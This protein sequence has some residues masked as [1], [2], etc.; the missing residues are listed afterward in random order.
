MAYTALVL[1][2]FFIKSPARH[3]CGVMVTGLRAKGWGSTMLRAKVRNMA[4][5]G[6]GEGILTKALFWLNLV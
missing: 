2:C 3:E 4:R 5:M 6:V 1:N